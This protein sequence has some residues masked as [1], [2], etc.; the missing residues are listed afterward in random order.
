MTDTATPDE[1]VK[2][3]Q[4]QIDS[5]RFWKELKVLLKDLEKKI[6]QLKSIG[7][8]IYDATIAECRLPLGDARDLLKRAHALGMEPQF[9]LDLENLVGLVETI[10]GYMEMGK[11]K[12]N[13]QWMGNLRSFTEQL[14]SLIL[15]MK[16]E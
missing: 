4:E 11:E 6:M 13:A 3:G 16:M 12:L 10:N 2:M 9:C 15:K 7:S 8:R 1:I 14:Y 5:D